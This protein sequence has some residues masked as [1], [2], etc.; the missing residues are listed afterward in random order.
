VDEI[1]QS[2]DNPH[3]IV[4]NLQPA[5]VFTDPIKIFVPL[6]GETNLTKW[7]IYHYD[8]NPEV[9]WQMAVPGDGWLEYREDHETM[10]PPTIELWLNH[11]TGLG[12]DAEDVSSGSSGG[13]GGGC[14]IA[15]AAYGSADEKH[16]LIFRQFRDTYLME[17]WA[18]R[19]FVRAYYF[20][21]PPLAAI[22]SRHEHVRTMV[23]CGLL[24]LAVAC[25][26]S[27]E[28][29]GQA[30]LI[31]FGLTCMAVL[32]TFTKFAYR[33]KSWRVRP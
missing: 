10:E 7:K 14:F 20:C 24:P 31:L 22:I 30:K 25:E 29:P 16:V 28:S 21:S 6:P 11:F 27:L 4:L 23:R 8:Q 18:G 17:H 33:R 12:L 9:R 15:T 26:Y 13:G 5:L 3:A 2:P 32:F 19:L 1:P